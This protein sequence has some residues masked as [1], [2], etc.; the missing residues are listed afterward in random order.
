MQKFI[1]ENN[2]PA[3]KYYDSQI[4]DNKKLFY[5]KNI[6]FLP[7][8][9]F[10]DTD[11]ESMYQEAK[12]LE[13]QYVHHRASE[14]KGWQS[15]C[16][17]G[18]SS[19][20]TDHHPYYGFPDRETAPYRWTDVAD[21]CPTITNFFKNIFGYTEYARIRIMKLEAGGYIEPHQ[22]IDNYEESKLGPINIALNNPDG[23]KFYM[24]DVGYLPFK[25]GSVIKLNLYNKHCVYNN[26][27][28]DRYHLI[29]H[30]KAGPTWPK[31]LLDSFKSQA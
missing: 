25:Q 29:V 9:G 21:W 19:I 14:S 20:H 15:L 12:R 18:L 1:E 27:N 2:Y 30:G 23:C 8:I 13:K 16:I 24:Q 10:E 3:K 7:I 11:W 22:D 26:S 28:E 4:D 5:A 17:H 31:R 6:P